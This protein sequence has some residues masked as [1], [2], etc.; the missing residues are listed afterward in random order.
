MEAELALLFGFAARIR[1][2]IEINAMSEIFVFKAEF[3]S[4]DLALARA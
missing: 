3:S 1:P 4:G 2:D